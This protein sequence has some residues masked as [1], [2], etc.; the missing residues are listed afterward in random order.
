MQRSYYFLL[1]M[2][3]GS[4]FFLMS[5]MK[6][7]GKIISSFNPEQEK[8]VQATIVVSNNGLPD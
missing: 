3:S 6:A 7:K 8:K 5:R 2:E 4:R 1:N